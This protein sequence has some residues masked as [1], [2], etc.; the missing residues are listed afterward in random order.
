M[1]D[2]TF[3]EMAEPTRAAEEARIHAARG[4]QGHGR[5]LFG[6]VPMHARGAPGELPAERHETREA[7]DPCDGGRMA[8]RRQRCLETEKRT[9][10][11]GGPYVRS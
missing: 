11:A 7:F 2:L 5:V 8:E 6:G 3:A 1:K 9:L 10:H 4:V